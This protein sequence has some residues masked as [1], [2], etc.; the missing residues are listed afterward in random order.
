MGK[1]RPYKSKLHETSCLSHHPVFNPWYNTVKPCTDLDNSSFYY[2]YLDSIAQ[3][4]TPLHNPLQYRAL[5]HNIAN[6]WMLLHTPQNHWTTLHNIGLHCTILA[7]TV[8]QCPALY[9]IGQD[10]TT[11]HSTV[12]H[13]PALYNIGQHCTTVHSSLFTITPTNY[14]GS[15]V[16][17]KISKPV[18][19]CNQ[20]IE[21]CSGEYKIPILCVVKLT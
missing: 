21:L 7:S 17:R 3:N 10:C 8:Q 5:K 6:N 18:C 4:H 16:A 1:K 19:G 2:K 20:N 15:A 12:Q 13:C 11:V 14:T 9:N